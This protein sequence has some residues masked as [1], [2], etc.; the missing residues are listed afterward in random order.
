MT[1]G[2]ECA[3]LVNAEKTSNQ[4]NNKA[5][6]G[7]Y[8]IKDDTQRGLVSITMEKLTVQD[9]G[10]HWCAIYDHLHLF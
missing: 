9:S 4:Y 10:E 3:V 8:S 7:R 6:Q 2:K 1:I 5:Q